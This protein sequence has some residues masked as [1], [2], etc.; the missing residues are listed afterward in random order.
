MVTDRGIGAD[1]TRTSIGAAQTCGSR[2]PR[3]LCSWVCSARLHSRRVA[4]LPSDP[5][6]TS[7]ERK[8]TKVALPGGRVSGSSPASAVG[9]GSFA[10]LQ[11]RTM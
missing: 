9:E 10:G 1:L 7:S 2:M 8:T 3:I 4:A 11:E 5:P 6:V